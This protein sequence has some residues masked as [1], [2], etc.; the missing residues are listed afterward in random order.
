MET[1]RFNE[2]E[3]GEGGGSKTF[4]PFRM[5]FFV[6]FLKLFCKR[7]AKTD[8]MQLLLT[9]C[10]TFWKNLNKIRILCISL[11]IHLNFCQIFRAGQ[12]FDGTD[13]G[14][15]RLIETFSLKRLN[16][17]FFFLLTKR[18]RKK[19]SLWYKSRKRQTTILD[20]WHITT[21]ENVN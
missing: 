11:E 18:E 1:E 19:Q 16:T 7:I 2:N 10:K 5:N 14:A 15:F 9:C 17:S 13:A 3:G 12:T 8:K 4:K 6:W 21:K 20:E